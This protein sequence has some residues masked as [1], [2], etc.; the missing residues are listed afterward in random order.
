MDIKKRIENEEKQY[1]LWTVD[2]KLLK[3]IDE[4]REKEFQEVK[5]HLMEEFE[6]YKFRVIQNAEEY[7]VV[8]AKKDAQNEAL[9]LE[10]EA[11]AARAAN[12]EEEVPP[13]D[14]KTLSRTRL[15]KLKKIIK[16]KLPSVNPLSMEINE[17]DFSFKNALKYLPIPM[18]IEALKEQSHEDWMK[19]ID[20]LERLNPDEMERLEN[21][22]LIKSVC[23]KDEEM[24]NEVLDACKG[25]DRDDLQF[26]IEN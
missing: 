16:V 17:F 22:I 25:I 20:F 5:K 3:Q 23:L 10:D 14:P 7:A 19:S 15:R 18:N 8:K 21:E 13:V 26:F 6:L 24:I 12:G 4:K 9:R 11:K 1:Q 2:E